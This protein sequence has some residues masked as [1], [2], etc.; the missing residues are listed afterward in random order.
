[1]MISIET[2]AP[3][4]KKTCWGAKDIKRSETVPAPVFIG[5][6]HR[7]VGVILSRINQRVRTMS[8]S[9]A[10]LLRLRIAYRI[11]PSAVF[12]LTPVDSAI[13]LND[14]F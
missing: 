7:K 12:M 2:T 8:F 4:Q 11:L 6:T 3:Q 1:M 5:T 14:M 13:S 9:A 10:I